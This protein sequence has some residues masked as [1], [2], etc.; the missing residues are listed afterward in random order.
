VRNLF[1]T[2]P[3]SSAARPGARAL[4]EDLR[5][6]SLH[7]AARLQ[8]RELLTDAD[9]YDERGLPARSLS[10]ARHRPEPEE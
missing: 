3:P 1:P 6:I 4:Y 7:S 5:A 10:T 8:G 9:L 2:G